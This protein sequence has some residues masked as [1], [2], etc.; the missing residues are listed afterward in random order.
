MHPLT[1]FTCLRTWSAPACCI[2]RPAWTVDGTILAVPNATDPGTNRPTTLLVCRDTWEV[3]TQSFV[4]HEMPVWAARASPKMFH[5]PAGLHEARQQ[6]ATSAAQLQDA[7]AS[8]V[9]VCSAD[10]GCSVWSGGLMR[11]LVAVQGLFAR[12]V[13]DAAWTPDGAN[14]LLASLDGS[15]AVCR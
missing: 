2:H 9:A 14:L 8:L 6:G 12:G 10:K 3:A 7:K 4:G 13:T 5:I 15:I 1:S 11:P